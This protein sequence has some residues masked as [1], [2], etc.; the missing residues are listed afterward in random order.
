MHANHALLD[1]LFTALGA[2]DAETMASC[3]DPEATFHDIAFH[4]E[5]R[6][7]IRDM[8]RMICRKETDL[9]V[10]FDILGADERAGRARLVETYRIGA[11]KDR[12]KSGRP[13]TNRIE[14]R[15]EFRDGLITSQTDECDPKAWAKQAMK[16]P[17]TAFL[18]GRIRPFRSF[19]A[20]RKLKK[21]LAENP[22]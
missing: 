4:L 10:R 11:S 20:G 21:F 2:H 18:A 22:G 13:V 19:G 8:W 12:P 9:K 17:V 6:E 1:K 3:Y 14:S 16:G 15:F 7:N 5:K